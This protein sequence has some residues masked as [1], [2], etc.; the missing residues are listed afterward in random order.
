MVREAACQAGGGQETGEGV[1]PEPP[2][3]LGAGPQVAGTWEAEAGCRPAPPPSLPFAWTSQGWAGACGP[4]ALEP[5][6]KPT[7]HLPGKGLEGTW[8][9]VAAGPAGGGKGLGAQP[10][11]SK[12]HRPAE[13]RSYACTGCLCLAGTCPCQRAL[14]QP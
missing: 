1:S 11:F 10:G 5:V 3:Q 6:A 4:P 14:A 8:A 7:I 13:L 2:A 9:G 12:V